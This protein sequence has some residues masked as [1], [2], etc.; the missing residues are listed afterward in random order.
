MSPTPL[1]ATIEAL[2]TDC[3][4]F[5][6]DVPCVPHKR[7][8]VHCVD[9]AG[10]R[11]PDYQRQTSN[12]LIIK[13]GAAGDVIRTT[14][15]LRRLRLSAPEARIWWLTLTTELVERAVDVALPFTPQALVTLQATPFDIIYNLDKDREA[16]ALT[17]LLPAREKRGFILKDGKPYPVDSAA[18]DKFMTGIFDDVSQANR[19]HYVEEIFDICGF[20]FS[21]EKYLLDSYADLGSRWK[22]PPGKPV[23]GLNTGCGGRW[24][25]RRWPDER[26]TALARRLKRSGYTVLLL[27]G[28]Q[29]DTL[30]KKIARAS[31][32][33]YFGHFPLTRFI[34]EVD[35]CQLIVTAVTMAM[36]VAI[37]L[38][39]K[40][41]LFN[42]VFNR[43][44]F[45]LYGLGTILEPEGGCG[46]YYAAQCSDPRYAPSGCMGRLHVDTVVE[47]VRTLLPL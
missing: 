20:A 29:E 4:W 19:K 5:R 39:K 38:G 21:G 27:G 44:E 37:G 22:I 41:V 26:W 31:G 30:N 40:L 2:A 14:P 46:C 6:G 15:L 10:K 23:V 32:A 16:C 17:S 43:N 11:C 36:H 13:L 25:T 3:R 12:I 24:I 1:R 33:L 34:N 42:N 28:Q 18:N 35:Q 45:E 7:H 8:G 47:T 9:A